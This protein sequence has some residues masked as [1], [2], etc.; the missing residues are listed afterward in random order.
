VGVLAGHHIGNRWPANSTPEAQCL[1][2]TICELAI[3]CHDGDAV[4]GQVHRIAAE[5]CAPPRAIESL[6]HLYL[7]G[8]CQKT[9]PGAEHS[10]ITLSPD[11]LAFSSFSMD[12][13]DQKVLLRFYNVSNAPCEGKIRIDLQQPIKEVSMV[14]LR[15]KKLPDQQSLA[16]SGG[17]ITLKVLPSQIITLAMKI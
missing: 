16:H 17:Q 1:G 15:G 10:F 13:K 9:L 4:E 7:R 11:Q 12:E 6:E 14:D 8:K 2:N 3:T 5:Y